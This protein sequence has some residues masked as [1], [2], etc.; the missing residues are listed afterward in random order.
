MKR[1]TENTV[2]AVIMLINAIV[3]IFLAGYMAG[4]KFGEP[5]E[6]MTMTA[7]LWIN[8]GSVFGLYRLRRRMGF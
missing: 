5:T 1:S 2:T 6:L 3:A 7:V 4:I 8:V